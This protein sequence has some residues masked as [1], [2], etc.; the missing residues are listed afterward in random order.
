MEVGLLAPVSNAFTNFA[1]GVGGAGIG[2]AALFV[3][4]AYTTLSL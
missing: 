3:Y 2:G 1:I 4:I